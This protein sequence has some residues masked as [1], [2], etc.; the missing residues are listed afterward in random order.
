MAAT[1]SSPQHSL[2]VTSHLAQFSI[3]SIQI[4]ANKN[5]QLAKSKSNIKLG[6][7]MKYYF[8]NGFAMM[9]ARE[10]AFGVFL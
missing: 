8:K 3:Q 4:S 2:I 10:Q 9:C 7:Y 5:T 1:E 6:I